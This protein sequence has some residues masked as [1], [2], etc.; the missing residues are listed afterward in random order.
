[1]RVAFA[2]LALLAALTALLILPS[3][4]AAVLSGANGRIV[5]ISGRGATDAEA[6]LYLRVASGSFGFGLNSGPLSGA[7][8]QHRHPTWSPDRTM[9]AFARGPGN[10]VAPDCDI[11]TLDLS[12][13]FA[14][15][16]NI[17]NTANINE[18]RPAWSPDGTRIAYESEVSDG[19]N[20][21]DVLVK[22]LDG[23]GT[24]NLTNTAGVIDGKPAWTPDSSEIY[25][26]RGDPAVDNSL[27]IVKEPSGGGTVAN[28]AAS[29][30]QNEF[31]PSLSP[32]GRQLCFTRGTGAA[33]GA[34]ASTNDVVVSLA[35][36]G[37]QNDISD[38]PGVADYNCTWSP[39]G[40]FVAYVRGAFG[41]GDLFMERGDDT[42]PFPIELERSTAFDGNPDWAPDG[43]P[44]CEDLTVDTAF[45]QPV[46]IP[47]QCFDSGPF[48]ERSFVR[49]SRGLPANG[50]VGDVEQGDQGPST[51]V[52]TPNPGFSGTDTFPINSFDEIAGF[53]EP[54]TV[55]VNVAATPV[56]PPPVISNLTVAPRRWKLGP[57]LP[58]ISAVRV[59]AKVRWRLSEAASTRLT[60]QRALPGRLV[61]KG[62]LK[63]TAA[64]AS[65][66]RCRRFVN[67]G[68]RAFPNARAGLNTLAFQGRLTAKKALGPGSHRISA[69]ARDAAGQPSRTVF[70]KPFTI[71]G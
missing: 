70:S 8:A 9:I 65:K 54:R 24:L 10:C 31:Q 59:G 67:A 45:E 1:M 51:V 4:A 5:Y 22:T 44:V 28:I 23:G 42:S 38:N 68:T 48:Y 7:A 20:Q 43:R 57:G 14:A 47:Y 13:P 64:N 18:D 40:I 21:V 56:D 60:F 25:Y 46:T 52:Y 53:G 62:C 17:T 6:K 33:F 16:V 69:Q 3:I 2:K 27:D 12:N 37:G 36:G 55:T 41:A 61:G 19:S 39:D 49:E 30:G 50:T 35:N 32:D 71:A 26:H 15:P 11:Y 34:G 29:G 58:R 63:P 66:P